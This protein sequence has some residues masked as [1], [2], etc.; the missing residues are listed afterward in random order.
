MKKE[1][2]TR[3]IQ[4]ISSH[5]KG[6]SRRGAA[7]LLVG[8]TK[9]QSFPQIV[10]KERLAQKLA[11]LVIRTTLAPSLSLPFHL[12]VVPPLSSLQPISKYIPSVMYYVNNAT[13][14]ARQ[15]RRKPEPHRPL[16]KMSRHP[17]W[18]KPYP[19]SYIMQNLTDGSYTLYRRVVAPRTKYNI[20]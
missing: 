17:S 12:P 2:P 1:K 4:G 9:T 15:R 18:I 3:Q 19:F 11:A 16:F 13:A 20:E 14:I 7:S 5:Y 10:S 6:N 8:R